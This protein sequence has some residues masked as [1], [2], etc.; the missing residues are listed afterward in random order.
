MKKAANLLA[1]WTLSGVEIPEAIKSISTDH[2]FDG[3]GKIG[4]A[5]V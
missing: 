2:F 5:H 4:R 1:E 3:L